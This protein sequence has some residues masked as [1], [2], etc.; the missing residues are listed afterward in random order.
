MSVKIDRGSAFDGTAI[1]QAGIGNYVL[2]INKEDFDNGAVTVDAISKEIETITLDAGTYAYKFESSKGAVQ[3]V[4]SCKLKAVTA[5]DGFEH[6]VDVLALDASQLSRDNIQK[7]RF[8][9]VIAIVPLASGKSIMYG[10]NVGLRISDF[11]ETP[12]DA[13]KGGT[14]KFI[15][16]TPDNDPPEIYT[17][18]I[19][20]DTF[21]VLSLIQ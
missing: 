8:Q 15:L 18:H 9:K 21:D 4:P 12:G 17:P 11:E 20:A 10:R 7:M 16:K 13:D 2:L 6:M 3:I 14:L 1:V 19:I 5:V